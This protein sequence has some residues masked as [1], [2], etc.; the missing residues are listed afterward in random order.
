MTVNDSKIL[1]VLIRICCEDWGKNGEGK[2][3]WLFL[4]PKISE[5]K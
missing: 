4:L 2:V 5:L 1:L 3:E